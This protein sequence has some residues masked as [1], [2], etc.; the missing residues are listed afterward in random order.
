MGIPHYNVVIATP[1]QAMKTEYVQS[2]VLTTAWLNSR[3][4]TY[5][6]MS[7]QSSFVSEAR[8]MTATNTFGNNW[9]TRQIGSGE[10]TY[11]KIVWIDSDI[12]WTVEDFERLWESDL[13]IVSGIYVTGPQGLVAAHYPDAQGRPTF[14]NKDE[15]MLHDQPVEVGGVGFGFVAMK[16]GV[17]ENIER[18]W[19]LIR[20]IKWDDVDFY[21]N[22]GEDYSW[23]SAAQKAGYGI[24][25]DPLVKVRHHKET[26]YA[27]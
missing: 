1:G 25:I 20:R 22:V 5:A 18:P 6:Y 11:D 21:T 8:E 27:A 3:G 24:W 7:K 10:F 23:C 2:L 13:D 9:Q 12:E 16:F 19:F 17:F 14:I 4:L 15:F 26:V